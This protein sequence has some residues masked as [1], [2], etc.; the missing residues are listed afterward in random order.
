MCEIESKTFTAEDLSVREEYRRSKKKISEEKEWQKFGHLP[1]ALTV[2]K[3][4]SNTKVWKTS[5]SITDFG[6]DAGGYT[7]R[8]NNFDRMSEILSLEE[9]I[10]AGFVVVKSQNWW[11]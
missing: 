2:K 4:L 10:Q 8:A 5:V 11:V 6:M 1:R 7:S 3:K 9:A